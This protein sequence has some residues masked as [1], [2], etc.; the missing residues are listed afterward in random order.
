MTKSVLAVIILLLLAFIPGCSDISYLKEDAGHISFTANHETPAK[1]AGVSNIFSALPPDLIIETI[2]WPP[3]QPSKGDN[4][5]FNVT[6]KNQ[7]SGPAIGSHV[8][9]Y[10]DEHFKGSEYVGGIDAGGVVTKTFTWVADAGSHTFKAVADGEKLVP[11]SNE[12]NNAKTVTI[13]A[14]YP[15]LIIEAITWSPANPLEGDNITFTVT[16][17]NQGSGRTDYSPVA[18]YV[19]DTYMS[20]I[21]VGAIDPGTTGNAAF[22]WIAQAGSHAIRAVADPQEK[23]AESDE[24]N[25]DK[26]VTFPTIAPDLIIQNVTF[27][28]TSPP[29][30][31]G[32]VTFTVTIKNQG[33][34]RANLSRAHLRIDGFLKGSEAVQSIAIGESITKTFT[35]P[36]EVGSHT[37]KAIADAEKKVS[38]L[39]ENNNEKEVTLSGAS[40]PDLIIDSIIWSPAN[41]SEGEGLTFTATIKNQ[42]N[43]K[44]DE[45]YV[46]CYVDNAHLASS[47][48][49]PIDAGA[50]DNKT[51][52]WIVEAGSHTIKVVADYH[53]T[54]T[55]GDETNNEK[56]VIYPLPPDL[57]IE[58]IT[59]SPAKPLESDNMTFIVTVKNQGSAKAD[60]SH[61]AY[62][63]D[64]TYMAFAPIA[65]MDPGATATDNDTFNW[66]AKAGLHAVKAVADP[67]NKVTEGNE[68][69]NAKTATFAVSISLSPATTPT[70]AP[71]TTPSTKAP[72]TPSAGTT[73]VQ[74]PEKKGWTDLWLFILAPAVWVVIFIILLQSRKR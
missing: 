61:V 23:V 29:P 47:P 8:Y 63:I 32:T 28:P 46:S 3:E 56:S 15:D 53:E 59:W 11:E 45:S 20:L 57:I 21:S 74:L 60:S 17:K 73:P 7:G 42:G 37:V 68:N 2:T 18:Y 6:I 52:T 71:T 1:V 12:T 36:A 67:Q 16:V 41:P 48:V 4:I 58:S 38:E 5:I 72:K 13:L 50:T 65:P 64:D 26:E 19:D 39:D 35:W 69:N 44:A 43:G 55:E 10:I 30:A 51:F 40:P 62:Y 22:Y 49:N 54:I 33:N 34:A 31:G 66:T 24:N 70:P 27:S 9:F 14:L 25:N